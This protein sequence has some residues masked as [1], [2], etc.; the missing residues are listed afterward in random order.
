MSNSRPVATTL[1]NRRTLLIGSLGLGG[2]AAAY[3]YNIGASVE[4]TALSVHAA[5][6]GA[7]NGDFTLIDIR[8]P[9]EWAR[10]GVP[11]GAVPLDMRDPDFTRKM[12]D[13]VPDKSA[14]VAL[15]C[16]RGVRSR[17][18]AN[19]MQELG[20]TNVIDVPE[21]MLGS[22]AGPGWIASGLPV[23]KL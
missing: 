9:D 4:G 23:T 14:P 16:A 10:T 7:R 19:R 1:L 21:G 17:G 18:L 3:W 6:L 5:Y 20:F 2:A 22:G 15:I 13:L 11:D 8:R 12:L